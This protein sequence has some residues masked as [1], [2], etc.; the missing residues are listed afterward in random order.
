MSIELC[1]RYEWHFEENIILT[2]D[3]QWKRKPD[4]WQ[5]SI[6]DPNILND[7][8]KNAFD[9]C[10]MNRFNFS[11]ETHLLD[12]PDWWKN[13]LRNPGMQLSGQATISL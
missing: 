12:A 6:R 5:P 1:V 13:L 9:G 8:M 11:E 4:K 7:M 2:F 10:E 3:W